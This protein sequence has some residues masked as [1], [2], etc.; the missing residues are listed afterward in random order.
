MSP[1]GFVQTQ[2]L[3]LPN[4]MIP[5]GGIALWSGA[6]VDI[7]E[8]WVLC[9]GN[10]GTPDLTDKFIVGAGDAYAVDEV[11]G[12]LVHDHAFTGDGHSHPLSPAVNAATAP[13]VSTLDMVGA[14]SATQSGNEAG[15][16]DDDGALPPFWSLAY[17]MR[18][19]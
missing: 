9:D 8:G 3:P 10:N 1:I 14:G 7:P 11:G 19:A 4:E 18:T 12:A 16:T 2:S 13:G 5:I 15:T 17:I 6:I